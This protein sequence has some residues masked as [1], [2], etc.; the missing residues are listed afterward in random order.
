[1]SALPDGTRAAD[2]AG[3]RDVDRAGLMWEWLR[4]DPDY[5]AWYTRA[6]TA[7]CGAGSGAVP[8]QW[9]LLFRR[10]P[11]CFSTAS[12]DPVGCGAGSGGVARRRRAG[13]TR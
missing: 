6:S 12:E 8:V 11:R 9:G 3:L 1:M 5:I 10:G 4:R 2:Y 13:E 7:T